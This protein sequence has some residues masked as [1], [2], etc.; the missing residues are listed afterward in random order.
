[1]QTGAGIFCKVINTWSCTNLQ[2]CPGQLSLPLQESCLKYS[3]PIYTFGL[4]PYLPLW[5]CRQLPR[6]RCCCWQQ[7]TPPLH[8]LSRGCEKEGRE[9]R[10][11]P[12][13]CRCWAEL[14]HCE[15]VLPQPAPCAVE[16]NH[17]MGNWALGTGMS[18]FLPEGG[19]I[20]FPLCRMRDACSEVNMDPYTAFN[21]KVIQAFAFYLVRQVL[22]GYQPLV[23]TAPDR[24]V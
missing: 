18:S 22:P 23:E 5:S 14:H 21:C 12:D 4:P 13:K 11:T 3:R 6:R 2:P 15:L 7:Q 16:E 19:D 8:T 20:Q 10:W 1:M 9:T 24:T 17:P